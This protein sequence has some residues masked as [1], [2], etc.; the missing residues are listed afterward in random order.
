MAQNRDDRLENLT[1]TIQKMLDGNPALLIGC[2]GSIPYG[3]PTMNDL[4]KEIKKNLSDKYKTDKNWKSFISDLDKYNNLELS[5]ERIDLGDKIHHDLIWTVWSVVEQ[6]DTNALNN[7]LYNDTFPL[8]TNIIRKFIQQTGITNIIT[9][10]YDRLIE[11][12]ID[13]AEG[14]CNTG[15]SN[16]YINKLVNFDNQNCKRVVNLYKVHGSIDWFKR[17]ET[18]KLFSLKLFNYSKLGEN[19]D[20]QIVTPGNIK[21]K[22]THY[23]PFRTVIANADESLKKSCAYLCIGYG[24]NDEHIQP[25]IIEEN[26]NKKKPIVIIAKDI[27]PKIEKLFLQKKSENFMII[28]NKKSG[29][30][31]IYYPNM[32]KE[33]FDKEYWKLDNFYDLWFG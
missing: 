32:K 29:G 20:P 30:S 24:F 28:S 17:K 12:A 18:N 9:T 14:T 21:Y 15:F 19:F 16:N 10:N 1:S 5:L 31:V 33:Y 25:I 3:L 26:R 2:G 4:L 27:T 22:E 6:K 23:E 7:F 8:L 11:Y 13:F